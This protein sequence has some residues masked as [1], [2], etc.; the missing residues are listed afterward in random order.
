VL[1]FREKILGSHHLHTRDTMQMLAVL[2]ENL[3]RPDDLQAISQ[4]LA[5]SC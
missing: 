4:R 5:E 3:D 1:A 2:Y